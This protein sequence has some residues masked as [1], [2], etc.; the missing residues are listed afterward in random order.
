MKTT[1]VRILKKSPLLIAAVRS[2]R[3]RAVARGFESGKYWE[4]RYRNGE[5]S[6]G[7]SYGELAAFK[8]SVINEFIVQNK[9][10]RI[11]ELGCG[12]GNQLALLA[13]PDYVGFDVSRT[14]IE[15]CKRR[16]LGDSTKNF[17][18][19]E[20]GEADRGVGRCDLMLSL[21]V[22]YHLTEDDVYDKYMR[23]VFAL[24]KRY[25]MI[26][27]DDRDDSEIAEKV[28]HVRHRRFTAWIAAYCPEWVLKQKIN[29]QFPEQSWCD[30]WIFEKRQ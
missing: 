17:I 10:R 12:D 16:F 29:N 20:Q 27:S 9:I 28:V 25:V 8:A 30:F 19:L 21:D 11:F 5:T 3:Q 26:Y 23:T 6:G 15:R 13:V 7:G 18:L 22:L 14:A 2:I 24:S 4:S 1:I